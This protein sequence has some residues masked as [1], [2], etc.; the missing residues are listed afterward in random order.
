MHAQNLRG[1][2]FHEAE[3]EAAAQL[4]SKNSVR[5][6]FLPAAVRHKKLLLG[7]EQLRDARVHARVKNPRDKIQTRDTHEETKSQPVRSQISR[8]KICQTQIQRILVRSFLPSFPPPPQFSIRCPG[9]S[10][11]SETAKIIFGKFRLARGTRTDLRPF[12]VPSH[13]ETRS[14]IRIRSL[15]SLSFSLFL[16]RIRP[17]IHDRGNYRFPFSL[18][19]GWRSARRHSRAA[20]VSPRSIFKFGQNHRASVLR[21]NRRACLSGAQARFSLFF[22]FFS[23]FLSSASAR[24]YSRWK[25]PNYENPARY[26]LTTPGRDRGKIAKCASGRQ[27]KLVVILSLFHETVLSTRAVIY[28]PRVAVTRDASRVT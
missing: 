23:F 13:A 15:L 3:A 16:S 9:W 25:P 8:V 18:G 28:D 11:I 10:R 17:R 24:R 20:S 22:T 1:C 19:R 2:T 14:E 7:A 4:V 12:C 27:G 6:R 5:S 21:D 26:R